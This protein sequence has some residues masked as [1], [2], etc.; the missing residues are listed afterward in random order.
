MLDDGPARVAADRA[1]EHAC[2]ARSGVTC[3]EGPT[4]TI[5]R[6]E[7][8]LKASAERVGECKIAM[9]KALL[10]CWATVSD[11]AQR[12]AHGALKEGEPVTAEDGRQLV[13]L[14]AQ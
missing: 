10:G 12:L 7:A 3:D 14:T 6:V 9:L 8:V 11:L 5:A 1:S 2:R 4:N 13:Y